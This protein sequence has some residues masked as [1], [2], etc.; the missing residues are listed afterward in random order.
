[1]NDIID[2]MLSNT[3]QANEELKMLIYSAHD[4]S[5]S[6]GILFLQPINYNIVDI[7]YGSQFAYE[8]HY[9]QECID[10]AAGDKAKGR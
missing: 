4:D 8:L 3:Y 10:K 2:K 6:N 7:P 1:M 9:E 5:I